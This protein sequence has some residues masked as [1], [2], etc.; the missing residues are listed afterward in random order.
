MTPRQRELSEPERLVAEAMNSFDQGDFS[1]TLAKAEAACAGSSKPPVG[2]LHL[3]AA[4]LAE[5]GRHEE[6]L[7]AYEDALR[8]GTDDLDLHWD[9]VDFLVRRCAPD[10]DPDLELALE[11]A[12]RGTRLARRAGDEEAVIDLAVLQA[13]ALT[14]LGRASAALEA[15][16]PALALA[17]EH[18]D[19]LAER[20]HALF[21]LNRLDEARRA[22]LALGDRS[23]SDAW[24]HHTLGLIAERQGDRSEAERRFAR[25]RRESP[26]DYPAPVELTPEAFDRVVEDALAELPEPVRR[27]LSNVAVTV[28]DIP[29]DADLLA[30]D[31]PHSPAILGL[32]R[33][34]P[35]GDKASMDPWSHFPSSIVLYQRNLERMARNRRDLVEQIR[36]TLLHEVGHFLGL[37]E[38]D[39]WERGLD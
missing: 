38:Q 12:R 5:L 33:G 26:E 13:I 35:L 24:I 9:A 2:A 14:D 39:L 18:R 15:L 4:A 11:L 27:Y 20:A 22:L 32:F 17:P 29:A 37:D 30:S 23:P 8:F 34:S 36:V 19:A 3:R 16:E 1:G 6:A 21:E 25:A 28:E 31:P 7:T 10:E